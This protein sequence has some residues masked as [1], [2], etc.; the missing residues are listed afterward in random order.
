MNRPLVMESVLV[1]FVVDLF[2]IIVELR[3]VF[4]HEGKHR[5]SIKT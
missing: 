5:D 1:A 4:E 3:L 2:S